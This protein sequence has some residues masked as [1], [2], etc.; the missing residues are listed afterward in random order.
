MHMTLSKKA[1]RNVLIAIIVL[2]AFLRLYRI[3]DTLMFQG[4]QGRDALVVKGII[5][6]GNL[7]LLGP[8]TSVGNMYLGPF[9][10]Y[11]MAPLLW[12]TYPSPVGPAY[13]VA[14]LNIVTIVLLFKIANK[15][16]DTAT[17]YSASFLFAINQ[18]AVIL[19]RFSWNPNIAPFFALTTYWACLKALEEKQYKYLLLGALS[20]GLLTQSHYIALLM[21]LVPA[22]AVILS[23]V[24]DKKNRLTIAIYAVGSALVYLATWLPLVMFDFRHNFLISSGFKEFMGS[25]ASYIRPTS[26]VISVL[27]EIPHRLIRVLAELNQF[28]GSFVAPI[29]AYSITAAT[30]FVT[31][32][33]KK[34]SFAYM[35]LLAWI[36]SAFVG[37]ALYTQSI[38]DHYLGYVLP[39]ICL[40]LGVILTQAMQRKHAVWHV[41]VGGFIILYTWSNLTNTPALLLGG[42]PPSFYQAAVDKILPEIPLGTYNIALIADNKDYRGMNYRYFFDTSDHP[43][44]NFED[45]HD[46]D[47][48][49]IIDEK[50]TK[51]IESLPIF[52]IQFPG[53]KSQVSQINIVE[54]LDAYIYKIESQ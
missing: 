14:L 45:Y 30:I 5:R 43:P 13:G 4:D 6:E 22:V 20:F 35:L 47:Y 17:A 39:A 46:L 42:P 52:E 54:G 41:L 9:Y 34:L 31:K 25:Q 8:V 7:T 24:H 37:T 33:Q 27:T 32:V 12:I 29:M 28:K 23:L 40:L 36:M 49:I 53:E 44:K 38:Y 19:S 51:D 16:F 3:E 50:S 1:L 15:Y 11:F 26:R 2:G 21:G 10:Y 18:V 48:L